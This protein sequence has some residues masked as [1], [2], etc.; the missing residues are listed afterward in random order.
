MPRL[1]GSERRAVRVRRAWP[2]AGAAVVLA[3]LL[4]LPAA[5]AQEAGV[6]SASAS[7]YVRTDTDQTTVITPRL[8]VGAPVAEATRVD[9]VYTVDVWTSA[10]IDIRTSASKPVTE[11]RD[12]I[13]L[14]LQQ[15]FTDV[16]VSGSYRY[17]TE[18]DYESHGAGV[19][20]A[21]DFADNNAQ[22]AIAGRGYF[23]QVGR[24][25]DPGF[26]RATDMLT[27]SASFTQVLD[28]E[29]LVQLIYE[30]TSQDGYL[31]SPY[32]FVR[33]A[34]DEGAIP[35]TCE[36]PTTTYVPRT[37]RGCVPENN[38]SRRLRHAAALLA[39]R[40]LSTSLSV[41]ASY[42]FYIDDWEMT[43]HTLTADAALAL[44]PGWLLSLGYR[45]YRQNSASHFEP[46]Y[47]MT[48]LPGHYTSDKELSALSSHRIE[49][50]LGRRFAL[51]DLGS[52]FGTVLRAAP[53]YFVYDE[54]LLLDHVTAL[55]LTLTV[56]VLL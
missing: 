47:P 19:S 10:S 55:E 22:L 13:D 12:E 28:T 43:S 51:D 5:R 36:Y 7:L 40:A 29:T 23:D 52:E 21:Y 44:D 25:G 35:S 53:S 32:R 39:R 38:P 42:R 45:F 3:A 18:Y 17:S 33:I 2:P 50:E 56:E 8:H 46:F 41:G 14:S 34:D 15:A 11:Q 37:L 48:S 20:A 1:P 16:T 49:L 6:P 27:A 4:A 9:L 26:E 54:Y 24:A 30:L 31:S